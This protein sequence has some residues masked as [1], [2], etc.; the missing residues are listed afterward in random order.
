[1]GAATS[2]AWAPSP[3]RP[4]AAPAGSSLRCYNDIQNEAY[5]ASER[6]GWRHYQPPVAEV[7]PLLAASIAYT[8]PADEVCVG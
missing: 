4:L 7:K 5:E 8:F 6:P 2:H 3:P 1:M